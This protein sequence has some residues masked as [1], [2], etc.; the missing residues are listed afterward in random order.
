MVA[1]PQ[2]EHH[3][4]RRRAPDGGMHGGTRM[5]EVATRH[6]SYAETRHV[7]GWR[8]KCTISGTRTLDSYLSGWAGGQRGRFRGV[9]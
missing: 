1:V 8:S 6:L 5:G 2:P 3:H 9:S 4:H 7:S